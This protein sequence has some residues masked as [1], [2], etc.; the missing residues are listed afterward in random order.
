MK[1]FKVGLFKF[2]QVQL[3]LLAIAWGACFSLTCG[4]Q[5]TPAMSQWLDWENHA[6]HATHKDKR[7]VSEH[8]PL[9]HYE[10]P[11]K[12]LDPESYKL[13]LAPNIEGVLFFRKD[14]QEYIRWP[15]NPEDTLFAEKIQEWLK[16]KG[17]DSTPKQYFHGHLTASRSLIVEAPG[18]VFFSAKV[19]TNHT[20]GKF[21]KHKDVDKEQIL[22]SMSSTRLAQN[23]QENGNIKFEVLTLLEETGGFLLD[24][25]RD[26]PRKKLASE[27][28]EQGLIIRDLGPLVTN[29]K[30]YLPGF[31]V[32]NDEVGVQLAALNG[33]SSPVDYWTQ[34][35]IIPVARAS[36]ELSA[37][38][39]LSMTSSHN[40]QWLVELDPQQRP[41]GKI[42]LRD[43]NDS[44]IFVPF[45]QNEADE[46]DLEFVKL[47]GMEKKYRRKD[48]WLQMGLFHGM[49]K[50]PSWLDRKGIRK[51]Q[52]AFFQA[53]EAQY[54]RST[55]IPLAVLRA[56]SPLL[57]DPPHYS[58]NSYRPQLVPK[59][60]GQN[61]IIEAWN[62]YLIFAP[63]FRGKETLRI[64]GKTYR[65]KD[66]LES[67]Q[68]KTK[69][70][71]AEFNSCK[72]DDDYIKYKNTYVE[73]IL[74]EIEEY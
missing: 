62:T 57:L 37:H 73:K 16:I 15:I 1:F 46:F 3:P 45:F 71:Q 69:E 61:Q 20:A 19:S 27:G 34:N 51:M 72:K 40:Q 42:V 52:K 17:L 56:K 74:D 43:F 44:S 2:R 41:T 31:S 24:M 10:I 29:H 6:N 30:L 32:L 26:I 8:F 64:G 21:H 50:L 23:V 39:G 68:S 55:G 33:S 53:F 60:K 65:C 14:G 63:C 7:N 67:I 18:P 22:E 36:A 13:N 58:S 4:A 47:M 12:Y 59:K 70:I 35:Y 48:L 5:L 66:V 9:F 11:V 49:G 25:K 54:S 38:L 28:W